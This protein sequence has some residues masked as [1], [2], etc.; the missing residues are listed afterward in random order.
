[1]EKI[2]FLLAESLFCKALLKNRQSRLFIDSIIRVF[3][4]PYLGTLQRGCQTFVASALLLRQA[5]LGG[6]PDG[7]RF[8]RA[9]EQLRGSALIETERDDGHLYYRAHQTVTWHEV[10]G[11]KWSFFIRHPQ[12]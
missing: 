4:R 5:G 9:V 7:R 11:A 1:M 3:V 12:K 2:L 8:F 6:E 10:V